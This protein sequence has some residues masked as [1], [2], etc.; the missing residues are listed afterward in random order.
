MF[1]DVVK[2]FAVDHRANVGGQLGGVAQ[3]QLLGGA[4]NHL[5]HAVGDAFMHT[6]QAQGRAALA[7]RAKRALHHGIG[8]LFGQRAAVDQ[9]GVDAA[10]LGDQRHDGA[11]FGGER[12]VD[13]FGDLGR[14]GKHHAGHARRSHQRSANGFTRAMGQL[15]SAFR[16]A[17]CN[18]QLDGL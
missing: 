17:G 11:V 1:V 4:L 3:A 6:Q 16:H 2:G 12:A 10:G 9:H 15:Q 8:N 7:R 13:D 18:H 14:A 5:N